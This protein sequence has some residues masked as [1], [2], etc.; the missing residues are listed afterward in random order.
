M[1]CFFSFITVFSRVKLILLAE[2][3]NALLTRLCKLRFSNTAS[4]HHFC[5]CESPSFAKFNDCYTFVVQ[6][7]LSGIF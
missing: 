7:I 1:V 4:S 2:V 3:L 5:D 6:N